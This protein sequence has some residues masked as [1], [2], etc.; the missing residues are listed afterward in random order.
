MDRFT[1]FNYYTGYGVKS[2]YNE[3]KYITNIDF[4]N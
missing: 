2:H 1:L 3:Q 4:Q